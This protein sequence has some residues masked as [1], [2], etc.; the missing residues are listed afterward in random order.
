MLQSFLSKLLKMEIGV[1]QLS[2]SG[3]TINVT[4]TKTDSL[5]NGTLYPPR[6]EDVFLPIAKY[7]LV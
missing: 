5:D 7:G 1:V 6:Y 3:K 4:L 2:Q